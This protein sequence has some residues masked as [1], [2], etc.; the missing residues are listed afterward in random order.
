MSLSHAAYKLT[1]ENQFFK[2]KLQILSIAILRPPRK[3]V[4][5]SDFLLRGGREGGEV[6]S[7]EAFYAAVRCAATRA[8]DYRFSHPKF[9]R[10]VHLV[11]FKM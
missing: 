1:G 7:V 11:N 9:R 6:Q 8:S 5:I 4:L 10:G 3:K 2:G